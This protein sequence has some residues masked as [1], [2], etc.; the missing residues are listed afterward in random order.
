MPGSD[1]EHTRL[2]EWAVLVAQNFRPIPDI[3]KENPRLHAKRSDTRNAA[4][5]NKPLLEAID[6]WVA[7][8]RSNGDATSA[9]VMLNLVS[10]H[11]LRARLKKLDLEAEVFDAVEE[12]LV[13]QL[14]LS[15]ARVISWCNT[16]KTMLLKTGPHARHAGL[17][18]VADTTARAFLHFKKR[19]GGPDSG[20]TGANGFHPGSYMGWSFDIACFVFPDLSDREGMSTW[21]SANRHVEANPSDADRWL[22]ENDLHNVRN[23]CLP[24]LP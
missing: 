16:I 23:M 20:G 14:P 13:R 11:D 22:D 4:M 6:E 24:W 15:P 2:F 3:A 8:V 18:I 12:T 10:R 17:I 9:A 19:K 1:D 7:L 5:L 21:K